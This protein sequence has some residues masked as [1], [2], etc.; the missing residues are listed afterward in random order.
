MMTA[1]GLRGPAGEHNVCMCGVWLFFFAYFSAVDLLT[2]KLRS[3]GEV[4]T[5]S[6][7]CDLHCLV[8]F[9]AL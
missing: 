2:E 1:G 4:V 8:A 3:S 9:T 6:T 5:G 7:Q